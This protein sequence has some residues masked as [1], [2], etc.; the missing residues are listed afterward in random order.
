MNHSHCV[1]SDFQRLPEAEQEILVKEPQIFLGKKKQILFETYENTF[2]I[3]LAPELFAISTYV[4]LK[5]SSR[6]ILFGTSTEPAWDSLVELKLRE[7][8]N[9]G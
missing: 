7:Q 4:T 6:P 3:D 5:S 2:K 1:S 9:N 8:N